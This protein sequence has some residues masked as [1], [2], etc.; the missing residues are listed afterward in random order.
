MKKV[1]VGCS[2]AI[3]MVTSAC[4]PAQP[5]E[6]SAQNQG[7]V[8]GQQI[9][10][11]LLGPGPINYGEIYDRP[12]NRFDGEINHS[13]SFRT[14]SPE[15]QDLSD[16][17]NKIREIVLLEDGLSPG[18]VFFAGRHAWVNVHFDQSMDS[19]DREQKISKLKTSLKEG[20]PR[21]EVHVNTTQS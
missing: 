19:E 11:G 13:P 12:T 20:A 7:A 15:R 6:A 9:G 18:M 21:Y 1:L 3:L 8:S 2:L 5:P 17:E 10:Y 14:L 16:D 4:T